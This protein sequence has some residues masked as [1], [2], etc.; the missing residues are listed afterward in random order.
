MKKLLIIFLLFISNYSLVIVNAQ[1]VTQEW[2][3]RYTGPSNDL[4][5]PFFQVDKYGNSYIAGTHVIND[6]INIL[7]V[8]YNTSGVQQ[9]AALY[10]YPG[11]GYFIPTG[12][13]IDSSGNAYVISGIALTTYT[14]RNMLTVKFNN[15]NG[16]PV[17][18]KTYFGQY[19]QSSFFDIKIDRQNN[20][21]VVGSSDSSHLIIRYNTNGD[22][23][24]VRKYHP[25]WQAAEYLRNCTIDDSLN[26][27]FTG[28]RR[29][30]G[31]F[32]SLYDS[33]LVAKYSSTGLLRWESVYATTLLGS[34]VGTKITAD[35]N[36]NA[37]IGGLSTISG[38]PVYLTL[39]Y[40]R[41]GIRQWA[42][43]YNAPG[44]GGGGCNLNDIVMD[45]VDNVLFVTGA[46]ITNGIQEATSIKYD[47]V[48]GDS[49]WVRGDTGTYKYGDARAIKIDN[50]GN[51]YIAG[52]TSGIGSGASVDMML[53]K[54]SQG[55][56]RNFIMTYNGPYNGV[57]IGRAL[58]LDSTNNI[59]VLSTSGSGFQISDYVIVKYNQTVGMKQLSNE[60][61]LSY[62]LEQNYPN[63]FNP[64]TKF[65]FQIP[66]F[67]NVNITIFD[68]LGR[69][70]EKPVNEILKPGVY[71]IDINGSNFASGTY[72]YRMTADGNLIDT[73]K[74]VVLK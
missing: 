27:I 55:G 63:P 68:V 1:P 5:G 70:V 8:K 48:T 67:S 6:S 13:A 56:V 73:K 26:I 9:W 18:A 39:K 2:V 36:G 11:Y 34:N 40:D 54:Y 60:L 20:I 38:N 16:S 24:W 32:G 22:S 42:K 45:R 58:G 72:F 62:R 4:Y 17:W 28:L 29:Y 59:Y 52:V 12:L 15:S 69:A 49:I 23:V 50:L 14:P 47:L 7:C 33:V 61:P 74:F 41:S 30:F 66:K 37:Y 53:I 44:S 51:S 3:A 31:P 25:P 65:R 21:Y 19:S 10:K 71:E 46:A 64:G 43:I 35:Q 57:D